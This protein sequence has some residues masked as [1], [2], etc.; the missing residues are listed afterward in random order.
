VDVLDYA[1]PKR[2]R[3]PVW[4]VAAVVGIALVAG[5]AS[6]RAFWAKPAP[7]KVYQP[8]QLPAF[9]QPIKD[10]SSKT[11][12]VTVDVDANEKPVG[13]QAVP[14]SKPE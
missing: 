3:Y 6:W 7:V 5:F 10:S 9:A 4:V 12:T 2:R 1:A 13:I 11:I 8:I 14:T